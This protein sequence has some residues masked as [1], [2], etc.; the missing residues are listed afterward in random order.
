[1]RQTIESLGWKFVGTC[2][3]EGGG[4]VF[5]KD[6]LPGV[7]ARTLLRKNSFQIIKHDMVVK[8]GH[9]YQLEQ[10]VKEYEQIQQNK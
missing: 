5:K 8:N 2:N 10:K 6:A 9:S 7:Q 4:E 1:M 3:C